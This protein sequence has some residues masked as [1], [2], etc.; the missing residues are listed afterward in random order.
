MCRHIVLRRAARPLARFREQIVFVQECRI[1]QRQRMENTSW[2]QASKKSSCRGLLVAT[3]KARSPVENRQPRQLIESN[4][5]C[6]KEV[7]LCSCAL[8]DYIRPIT[9]ASKGRV[10]KCKKRWL[11]GSFA[12]FDKRGGHDDAWIV[13]RPFVVILPAKL[14]KYACG[15]KGR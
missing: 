7:S 11:A 15:P 9:F 1:L 4:A 14:S 6:T 12:L 5:W 8:F 3:R 2:W 10:L 13:I